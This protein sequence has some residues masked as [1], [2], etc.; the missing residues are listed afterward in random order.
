MA[1]LEQFWSDVLSEAPNRVIVRLAALDEP[2]RQAIL[3]HLKR[4]AEEPGWS[5]GQRRRAAFA[6]NEWE[7]RGNE[8]DSSPSPPSD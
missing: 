6:L 3:Q 8:A 7:R 1:S 5:E 4:M 2:D